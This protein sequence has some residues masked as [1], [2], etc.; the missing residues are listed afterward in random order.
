M[1][2]EMRNDTALMDRIHCY[3]PGWDVPKISEATKTNHFGLVSDFLS[4]CWS[5]LRSQSR[6]AKLQGRFTFGGALS[7]R[8]SEA[9]GNEIG[10]RFLPFF[11]VGRQR[12][13]REAQH[14][15][16]VVPDVGRQVRQ[17]AAVAHQLVGGLRAAMGYTGAKSIADFQKKAKFVR[18]SSA[19]LNESH[20]HSITVT[21]ES[22]NYPI[23]G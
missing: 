8:Q 1:P 11:R 16:H 4:E 14:A 19:G 20:V 3:L 10:D 6:M 23:T 15:E 22:P 17:Q 12:Q 13:Q 5:R 21:R 2:P 7:G 18:I 9:I